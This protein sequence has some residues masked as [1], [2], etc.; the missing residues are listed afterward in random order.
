MTL[1]PM[2]REQIRDAVDQVWDKTEDEGQEHRH[3]LFA[4]EVLGLDDITAIAVAQGLE[5][6]ISPSEAVE[7]AVAHL[8]SEGRYVTKKYA[9][10]AKLKKV[11][12]TPAENG[13]TTIAEEGEPAADA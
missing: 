6:G 12:E 10:R 9:P 4:K 8:K 1:E 7:I 11:G 5:G 13:T 3:M 2:T